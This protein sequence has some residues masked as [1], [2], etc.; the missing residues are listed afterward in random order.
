MGLS[1][2]C[3]HGSAQVSCETSASIIF[4]FF[5]FFLVWNN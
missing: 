4:F 1:G 2:L 3:Y 5:F